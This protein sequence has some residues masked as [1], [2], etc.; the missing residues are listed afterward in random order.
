LG[1]FLAVAVEPA[2]NPQPGYCGIYPLLHQEV[3]RSN[4]NIPQPFT[5]EQLRTLYYNHELDHMEEMVDT[6]LQV[7]IQ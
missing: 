7:S 1:S 6:F 5:S 2:R 3:E 4:G